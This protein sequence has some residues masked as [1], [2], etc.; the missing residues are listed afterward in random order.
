MINV[1]RII[2]E[3][4]GKPQEKRNYLGASSVGNECI[5]KTQYYWLTILGRLDPVDF[6]PRIKRIFD[7]GY[8]Y[9]AK[10]VEWLKEVGFVFETD[11]SKL[12]LS[13]FPT[14]D[15]PE[16]RFKGHVDGVLL[17]GPEGATYPM[18]WENKC[19]GGK[20][21]SHLKE[22]DCKTSKY[23]YYCQVQI[24]MLYLK[25]NKCLFTA[26]NADTM[27]I[28]TELI[29]F[30]KDKADELINIVL[31]VFEYTERNKFLSKITNKYH[32][33]YCDYKKVCDGGKV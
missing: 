7:R 33:R 4:F 1:Q 12:E 30:D 9:E 10:M 27:E 15:K 26:I 18:L 14:I 13:D 16:G 31:Q 24:Y 22:T 32:C 21:W 8:V 19:L 23:G 28:Y 2:D 20:G 5:R 25:L 11:E 17:A 29:P 3:L 6:P